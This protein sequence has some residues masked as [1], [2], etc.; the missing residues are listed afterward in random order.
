MAKFGIRLLDDVGMPRDLV[1]MGVEAETLGYDSVWY[2]HDTF[3]LNSWVLTSATAQATERVQIFARTNLYTTD[4]CEIA[5]YIA[6]LD[7]LSNGR[8]NL[9]IGLHTTDMLS[10]LGIND[11]DVQRRTRET[12]EIVRR[13]LKGEVVAY[14]G[15]EFNWTEKAFLRFKPLREE[16]PIYVCPFGESYLELSGELGDGSLPM[17]APPD[18]AEVLI[19]PILRGARK[20]G[21]DP[22]ELDIVA[23]VWISVSE[24][25]S[26][27]KEQM[28]DVAAYFGHYLDRPALATIDLTPED[29]VP[30]LRHVLAGDMPGARALVTDNML[31]LGIHGTPEECIRQLE[32]V[33]EAGATHISLGGPMGPNPREAVRLIARRVLPYFR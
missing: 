18:S 28:K 11:V 24:D 32:R 14:H 10:W 31:N 17:V 2:P 25:G 20:A 6:T 7:W 26:Q 5:T 9:S 21:R 12:T 33:V 29:F 23:F 3:R 19:E 15:A 4:P 13:L 22:K 16:V 27:T 8:A 1:A 30:V